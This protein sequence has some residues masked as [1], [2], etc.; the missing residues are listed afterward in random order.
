MRRCV[1]ESRARIHDSSSDVGRSAGAA[2][3]QLVT[4]RRAAFH[5]LLAS[6]PP[7]SIAENENR[8]SCVERVLHQ[9]VAGR[10]RAVP[11]DQLDRVDAGAERLRHAAPVRREHGRV[12]DHVGERQLPEQLE[13]GEDHAVLPEPDDL[14]GG[15]LDVARDRSARRSSVS[16][17][18]PSVANGQSADENHV[19]ST[20]VS[21]VELGRSRTRRTLR[22]RSPRR[23]RAR[24]GSTRRGI[25]WPHQICREM[26]QS[27]AFSS[28]SIA[29]RCWTL[30]V[31]AHPA[32]AQRLERALL[33][34]V[35]RSTTTA[36]RRAARSA[37]WQRSQKAT[38]CR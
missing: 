25:W 2:P 26:H 13:P 29:K 4:I 22:A 24:P 16:S 6:L 38:A 21:R 32:G 28:E 12:D 23:S 17:G 9:P 1:W 37:D 10:V 34:L 27:G 14:A 31:V 7:S 15:R 8:T 18:H 30:G 5:S 19:S 20:S 11:V 33:E 3:S 35:H 36:A